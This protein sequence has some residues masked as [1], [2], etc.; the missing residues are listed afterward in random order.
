[1][2]KPEEGTEEFFTWQAWM[3]EQHAKKQEAIKD[4]TVLEFPIRAPAPMPITDKRFKKLVKSFLKKSE[5]MGG[6]ILVIRI[7]EEAR[8]HMDIFAN[9]TDLGFQKLMCECALEIMEKNGR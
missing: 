5:T 2:E 4:G 3:E 8:D 1:M 6:E 9:V 7:P